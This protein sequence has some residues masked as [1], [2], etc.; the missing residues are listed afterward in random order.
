[1]PFLDKLEKF[2]KLVDNISEVHPYAKIAWS[3]ISA[4]YKIFQAQKQR[5]G[6]LIHLIDVMDDTYAFVIESE[7][8]FQVESQRKV[9][10][11]LAIQTTECGHFIVDYAKNK[12]FGGRTLAN[13]LGEADGVIKGF[14]SCFSELKSAVQLRGSVQTEIVV[15]Q[16]IKLTKNIALDINFNDMQYVGDASFLPEKACFPGTRTEIIETIT[17]WVIEPDQ[18]EGA[19]LFWMKGFA[20]SGK[21]AVAHTIANLFHTGKRL[22]CQHWSS[23]IFD[24]SHAVERRADRVFSKISRDLAAVSDSWKS[25]LGKIIQDSPDL[26][27]TPSVRRQFEELVLAPAKEVVFIG[28][29]LIVIDA[30]D[31]CG[32]TLDSRQEFLHN[33]ST[34]LSELPP[35]FRILL[36]SRP[37]KEFEDAFLRSQYVTLLDIQAASHGSVDQD[38]TVYY[39]ARLGGL[40]ELDEGWPNKKWLS[41]LTER[42]EGLF[43]WA[44]TACEYILEPGWSPDE[45]LR[46][47]LTPTFT[48]TDL[49][50]LSDLYKTILDNI[51][52][53]SE[54]DR[55][56]E[57]F[58]SVLGRI[59]C[60]RKPLSIND[61]SALRSH[62]ESSSMVKSIVQ[63]MGPVLGGVSTE[64]GPIQAL[65]T[66]F[67]DFLFSPERSGIYH[68]DPSQ[69]EPRLT[70]ACLTSMNRELRLNIANMPSSHTRAPPLKDIII[71]PHLSYSSRF[72]FDHLTT[73]PF[74]EELVPVLH[75][76]MTQ[77]F[78][79]WLELLGLYDEIHRARN[80]MQ[81]LRKWL[82]VDEALIEFAFDAEKFINAFGDVITA[83]P[84]HL[85]LSALPFAPLNSLI[86]KQFLPQFGNTL[87]VRA[88]QQPEYAALD[89]TKI[90]RVERLT[91]SPDMKM[92]ATS[93]HGNDLLLW[94]AESVTPLGDPMTGHTD[95]IRF[96]TFSQDGKRLVTGGNDHVLRVWDT[97]TRKLV[98]GP[99]SGHTGD[100]RAAHFLNGHNRIVSSS[101][102]ADI[103]IWDTES[104][105]N[106]GEPLKFHRS[107][108]YALGITQDQARVASGS[109]DGMIHVWDAATLRCDGHPTM[110]HGSDIV[111]SLVYSSDGE[112]LLSAG[113]DH[114]IRIWNSSTGQLI[115]N[116]LEDHSGPITKAIFANNDRIV[117][118]ASFPGRIRVWNLDFDEDSEEMGTGGEKELRKSFPRFRSN[119]WVYS[120][121]DPEKLLFWVPP[122]YHSTFV[123]GCCRGI[124]G[125]N[126]AVID[127]DRF[128]H[129]DN[130]MDCL[131]SSDDHPASSS[132]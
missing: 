72:W 14:E 123:W 69:E 70:K 16:T 75:T 107:H 30:L 86:A 128:R 99:L 65:H 46:N 20:G 102:D 112:R 90:G 77:H 63:R 84:P 116:P 89:L 43:Q 39:E 19:S 45:Q 9:L 103:R 131:T 2:V 47:L 58:R 115:G 129:G 12:S 130:W 96:L 51:F 62:E 68:I 80:A 61:L 49:A 71:A 118:S 78:L 82:I 100:V 8:L 97:E 59:L 91:Y 125:A 87:R 36:T 29:I 13:I 95:M 23:F 120:D 18:A 42:S 117:V 106:I 104:G 105:R 17:Q 60:A 66:S 132:S 88:G 31:E 108:V 111:W 32:G 110:N 50:G 64:S 24:E 92:I 7:E 38:L 15:L 22:G 101:Y 34:R 41:E 67:R 73:V 81:T 35:N 57:R 28:P 4:G 54:N 26:R 98:S 119:G 126:A 124:I 52:R 11:K 37:Q 122:H 113:D 114:V 94:D 79:H 40:T 127:F 5:D 76:F 21:S 25:A 55:R 121:D 44:F 6:A 1:M 10:E 48:S 53:F 93:L 83:S 56:L 33:L 3:V 109:A 74:S 85:Y 27:H